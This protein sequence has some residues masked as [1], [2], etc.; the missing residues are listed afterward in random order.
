M[1]LDTPGETYGECSQF[2]VDNT[3]KFLIAV[4]DQTNKL[5]VVELRTL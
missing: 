2:Q 3:G 1:K 4:F 5:V